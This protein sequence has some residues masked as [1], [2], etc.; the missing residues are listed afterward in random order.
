MKRIVVAYGGVHQAFQIARAAAETGELERFYC[1]VFDRPGKWGG[2]LARMVGK[3]ATVN[4]RC[5]G[6]DTQLVTE[7]PWPWLRHRICAALRPGS[8]DWFRTNEAFDRW[9]ARE[10]NRSPA[11]I[12]IGT[13]T[14]ARYCFQVAGERGMMRVLDCPQ[15]HPEFIEDILA[16][17]SAD[18]GIHLGARVDSPAMAERKRDEFASA[19]LMLVYS[20]VHQRSFAQAGFKSFFQCPL[21]ADPKLWYRAARAGGKSEQRQDD[22]TKPLKVLFVGAISLRK[23]IPYLLRAVR[24]CGATV[25]LTLV[26]A[27]APELRQTLKE[28]DT[29]FELLPPQS[30]AALRAIYSQHDVLALPSLADSFGFVGLEAMACGLPVIVSE[31]CGVPVPDP[32]WRVPVMNAEAIARRILLYGQNRALCAEHGQMATAFAAQFSPERYRASLKDLF[33]RLLDGQAVTPATTDAA[34]NSWRVAGNLIG[35]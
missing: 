2:L 29:Y 14:C 28:Y 34:S 15:L 27:V 22:K 18:C 12:F 20:G 33:R 7:H 1:S 17:A 23:G 13:E 25:K 6:L 11:R 3:N 35:V 31:N 19:D 5:D 10:M 16:R 9:A 32:L 26:G 4:R 24:L 8:E 21:W 30:K